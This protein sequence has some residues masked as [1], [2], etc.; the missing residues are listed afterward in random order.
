MSRLLHVSRAC[1]RLGTSPGSTASPCTPGVRISE[2]PFADGRD[3]GQTCGDGL[4][5]GIGEGIV[6]RRQ[7]ENIRGGKEDRKILRRRL[8]TSRARIDSGFRVPAAGD[9]QERIGA[10]KIG[11]LDRKSQPLPFPAG[12]RQKECKTPLREFRG[13]AGPP[14]GR[15]RRHTAPI[16]FGTTWI[17]SCRKIVPTD[18]FLGDHARIYNDRLTVLKTCRSSARSAACF[19]LKNRIRRLQA[20]SKCDLLCSHAA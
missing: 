18:D 9:Q 3:D 11:G 1:A 5:A 6:N 8:K 4:Q 12:A 19:K 15:I 2:K 10:K 16:P 17:F 14:D 13:A 7:R 20:D